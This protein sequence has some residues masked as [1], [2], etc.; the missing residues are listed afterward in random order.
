ML[1]YDKLISPRSVEVIK[2][3]GYCYEDLIFVEFIDYVYSNTN[4]KPLPRDL[5]INRYN[6]IES[7]RQK[8]IQEIKSVKIFL[9][10]SLGKI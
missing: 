6:H 10:F 5:Q 8:K 9:I 7:I 4:V 1:I 2:S 3:L